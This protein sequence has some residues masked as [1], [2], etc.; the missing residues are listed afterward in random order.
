MSS[1]H[2]A[3]PQ[4]SG[5]LGQTAIKCLYEQGKG[6]ITVSV[7]EIQSNK[8]NP[9][10]G[11][12]VELLDH[13]GT[14]VATAP[15]TKW[16]FR[17]FFALAPGQYRVRVALDPTKLGATHGFQGASEQPVTIVADQ[18]A[19]ADFVLT[20][21]AKPKVRLKRRR[22]G[23]GVEH[24]PLTIGGSACRDTDNQGVAELTD[25]NGILAGQHA[26]VFDLTGPTR[27]SYF[28]VK[29]DPIDVK[30]GSAVT[31]DFVAGERAHPKVKV[32]FH[33]T[34]NGVPDIGV[35]L[36]AVN[37]TGDASD[38]TDLGK[39]PA[40]TGIVEVA[41]A[42]PG[43]MPGRYKVTLTI[44]DE[45]KDGYL[46]V[47]PAA[48]IDV[49]DG[50]TATFTYEV[51]QI[52]A[53]QVRVLRHDGKPLKGAAVTFKLTGPTAKTAQP[54]DSKIQ[55]L[56]IGDYEVDIDNLANVLTAQK[57][58]LKIHE[59]WRI[60]PSKDG[61][62][63]LKVTPGKTA[64]A[65]FLLTKYE[66]IQFV[67][68]DIKPTTEISKTG[69]KVYKGAKKSA[70][71]LRKRILVMKKAMDTAYKD[72]SID[73]GEEVLKVFMA[74]EFFFRGKEGAYPF[75]MIPDIMTSL[76]K[77]AKDAKYKDWLFV[78]GTAIGYLKHGEDAAHKEIHELAVTAKVGDVITV[79]DTTG[80]C[81]RIPAVQDARFDWTVKQ[82]LVTSPVLACAPGAPGHFDLTLQVGT[83]IDTTQ[84]IEL[85]EPVSTEILNVA[86]VQKG[87]SGGSGLREAIIYKEYVSSV[88]F[89]N[90]NYYGDRRLEI[91]GQTRT[92]IPTVGSKDVLG[93]AA[94]NTSEINKSGLGGG[95]VFMVDGITF[96]LEVCLDHIYNKLYDFYANSAENGDP[97]VQVFLLPSWG[98]RL[99]RAACSGLPNALLFNVDGPDGSDVAVLPNPV[100]F[101]CWRCGSVSNNPGNCATTHRW[102]CTTGTHE[103]DHIQQ[104]A[105]ALPN[106]AHCGGALQ[107]ARI[108]AA[109]LPA[110]HNELVFQ[111]NCGVCGGAGVPAP[112]W[113][114]DQHDQRSTGGGTCVYGDPLAAV[115]TELEQDLTAVNPA[116]PAKQVSNVR[117]IFNSANQSDL[118]ESKGAITVYPVKDVP[119]AEIV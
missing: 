46:L 39:T 76:G 28:L 59:K 43:I 55:D 99:R 15:T 92:G 119:Q 97:K 86:L 96:G 111:G 56:S 10:S 95:S 9:A 31:F 104:Q 115:P 45:V 3:Q 20:R 33:T 6:S 37:P 23:A 57:D 88:D 19:S 52:G 91:H 73:H 106:C 30:P 41:A 60:G 5:S 69:Q 80:F 2:V 62:A 112:Y 105:T 22:D 114:C 100:T 1:P 48:T 83:V 117:G 103:H 8:R 82:G 93:T 87:G 21:Q 27:H 107:Q 35:A 32:V 67:A 11:V 116:A 12:N 70:T 109:A 75:E 72:G 13:G 7:A 118:F 84:E 77:T 110:P 74:P 102:T 61:K 85:E 108:C 25:A 44:P 24:V 14:L 16:G 18:E 81:R 34:T 42:T 40:V 53:L 58:P 29:N 38:H 94:P 51:R 64:V 17:G 90:T 89:I 26:V 49:P 47:N 63:K 50:S 101:T 36:D 98:M 71:D 4:Q 66:K 113:Y 65:E 78:Y 68:F 54:L 79:K